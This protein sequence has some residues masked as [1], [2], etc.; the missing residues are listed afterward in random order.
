MAVGTALAFQ[1]RNELGNALIFGGQVNEAFLLQALC[2]V[3]LRKG[4]AQH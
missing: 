1:Q 2:P 3:H 4:A